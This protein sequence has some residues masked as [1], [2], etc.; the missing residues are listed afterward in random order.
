MRIT[1]IDMGMLGADAIVAGSSAMSSRGCTGCGCRGAT[2]SSS[3]SLA[4]APQIRGSSTRPATW[5]CVRAG[6]SSSAR[7]TNGRSR[8]RQRPRPRFATSPIGL[9][10]YG[11]PGVVTDGNDVLGV[12]D[13]TAVARARAGRARRIEAKSY[14]IT[15]HSAATKTDLRLRGARCLAGSGSDSPFL[16]LPGGGAGARA[17]EARELAAQARDEVEAAIEF[18]LGSPR[19]EPEAA[20]EDVYAPAPWRGVGGAR[21]RRTRPWA[22]TDHGGGPERGFARGDGARSDRVRRR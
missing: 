18:A 2:G 3:A 1:A 16:A 19:P 4:T 15:A 6:S 13:V 5:R 14:R 8:R 21:R 9:R 12:R 20:T 17:D 7:T 10:E 11:F 22:R